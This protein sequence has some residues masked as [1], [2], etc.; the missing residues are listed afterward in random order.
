MKQMNATLASIC[1]GTPMQPYAYIIYIM[2]TTVF[3]SYSYF[4]V[5]LVES[6]K[7][8]QMLSICYVWIADDVIVVLCVYPKYTGEK[9]EV[10]FEKMSIAFFSY[11]MQT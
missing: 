10:R 3:A 8:K 5:L 11:I 9:K 2:H 1:I 4:I 6:K 7:L